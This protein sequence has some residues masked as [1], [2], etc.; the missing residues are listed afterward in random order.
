MSS[1]GIKEK[2]SPSHKVCVIRY[3][4]FLQ[5]FSLFPFPVKMQAFTHIQSAN[6]LSHSSEAFPNTMF[7]VGFRQWHTTHPVRENREMT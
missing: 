4:S 1:L 5:F 6:T 3:F 2:K 7:S